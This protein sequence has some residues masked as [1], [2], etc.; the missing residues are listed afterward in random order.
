MSVS[1][2]T[3]DPLAPLRQLGRSQRIS[4]DWLG[5]LTALINA[6]SFDPLFRGELLQ[7]P[8]DHPVYR[9]QCVVSA[10]ERVRSAASRFHLCH[11]HSRQWTMRREKGSTFE[12]FLSF[13]RPLEQAKWAW[14]V[15]CS[16]CPQRPATSKGRQALCRRHRF[17]WRHARR[18][19]PAVDFAQWVQE[20]APY[21]TFGGCVVLVCH[22]LAASPLGLC[23]WHQVAYAKQG[24]PG[25]ARLPAKWIRRYDKPGIPTPVLYTDEACFRSWCATA[26]A[27]NIHGQI[28]LR[29]LDPLIQAEIRWGLFQH[30]QGDRA[31]WPL[32]WVQALINCC[33]DQSGASLVDL[34]AS[35]FKRRQY[36]LIVKEILNELRLIYFSPD[37]TR[38]AGFWRPITS[39]SGSRAAEAL[40]ASP[41]SPRRGYEIEPGTLWP[42]GYA[43]RGPIPRTGGP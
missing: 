43:H 33:R 34:E 25:G 3:A 18:R 22:D 8:A 23:H 12:E 13:A 17:R 27:Q 29:G 11:D 4:M 1:D 39:G 24:T 9:W 14:Q 30:T 7:I 31:Y 38:P 40:S 2:I 32:P 36:E 10:C 20:Q 42:D 5:L 19:D 6:P 21:E 28:N 35:G 15:P 26:S 41:R 37:A 16:I